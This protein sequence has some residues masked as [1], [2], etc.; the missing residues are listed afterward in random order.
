MRKSCDN[1]ALKGQKIEIG[2]TD[3]AMCEL[4]DCH[5]LSAWFP[6]EKLFESLADKLTA[7]KARCREL[8]AELEEYQGEKV[9]EIPPLKGLTVKQIAEKY[10]E[11]M[12]SA[13]E[14]S[15]AEFA[16]LEKRIADAPV[17]TLRRVDDDK[18]KRVV[19]DT[20][21]VDFTMRT[22][23]QN[24]RVALVLSGME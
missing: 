9:S 21:T 2:P 8:E 17:L 22:G 10:P 14:K 19:C 23:S 4:W 24:R 13:L 11:A 12:V 18:G 3:L 20:C 6:S 16:A 1:C 15:Y 5:E 7:S